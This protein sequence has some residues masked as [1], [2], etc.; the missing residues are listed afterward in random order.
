MKPSVILLLFLSFVLTARPADFIAQGVLTNSMRLGPQGPAG[1]Y[2]ISAFLFTATVTNHCWHILVKSVLHSSPEDT[3]E[4]IAFYDG[5]NTHF[6]DIWHANGTKV[7]E[8]G[9][10]EKGM[11]MSNGS[12]AFEPLLWGFGGGSFLRQFRQGDALQ[13]GKKFRAQKADWETYP[14]E[15][16]AL[17]QL[18]LLSLGKLPGTETEGSERRHRP[19]FDQGYLQGQFYV[20]EAITMNGVAIPARFSLETFSPNS[21]GASTNDIRMIRQ[22][23]CLVTN[24]IEIKK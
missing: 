12:V 17:R 15:F 14:D 16:G 21:N 22:G 7:R 18:R 5:T 2:K 4:H 1:E 19:P 24:V 10:T 23:D 9:E 8:Y 20:S 11:V 13:Y 6:I 3:R